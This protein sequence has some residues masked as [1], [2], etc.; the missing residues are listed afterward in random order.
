VKLLAAVAQGACFVRD[1]GV[2]VASD[3]KSAFGAV[4]RGSRRGRVLTVVWGCTF[5]LYT[6]L[7]DVPA[8]L[9]FGVVAGSWGLAPAV[10][11]VGLGSTTL[12]WLLAEV[13]RRRTLSQFSSVGAAVSVQNDPLWKDFITTF[14]VGVPATVLAYPPGRVPTRQRALLLSALYGFVG[15]GASYAGILSVGD[16]IGANPYL[17]LAIG[18]GSVICYRY[19]MAVRAQRAESRTRVLPEGHVT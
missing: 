8:G 3:V 10:A 6:T 17:A 2:L 11:A 12:A 4:T 1:M 9:I 14:G 18:I 13:Q 7:D 16:V 19:A 15:Q 5:A